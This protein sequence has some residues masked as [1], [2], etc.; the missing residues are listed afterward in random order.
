M[1]HTTT[2]DRASGNKTA[3]DP[4]AA[5]TAQKVRVYELAKEVGVENK[6]L[7][8]RVRTLGIEIKNH[9]SALEPDDVARIKRALDKERHENFY[10]ILRTRADDRA[11]GF[12]HLKNFDWTHGSAWLAMGIGAAA[13]RGQ[14]YGSEALQLMVD[15]AFDELGLYRLSAEVPG[16]N[17]GALRFFERHS[18]RVEVRRRQ[19]LQR[20][21]QRW[22]V[23]ILGQ[24]RDERPIRT[25][26][27]P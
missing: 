1:M 16:N 18:F 10:F 25:E 8:S 21:G 12:A 27:D 13:G 17:L 22:D 7:I 24:L 4:A 9:M 26:S 23:L 14:G 6:D 19:A 3:V 11:V 20:D 2:G 15:Y 5:G